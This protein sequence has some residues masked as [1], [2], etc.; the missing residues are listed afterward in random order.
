VAHLKISLLG[1][2]PA[3]EETDPEAYRLALQAKYFW[4]RRSPGD[5]EKA[6]EYYQQALD[7]D[8][9]YALAWAGLSVAYAVQA[10]DGRIS[11]ETG[12]LKAREAVEMALSLDPGSSDAHV[13]MAQ[14]YSRDDNQEA[15]RREYQLALD[16]DP[17]SPLALGAM[18]SSIWKD[19]YLEEGI[20][21]YKNAE[22]IDPLAPIWPGN[23]AHLF[24]LAGRLDEAEEAARKALELSPE[25]NSGQTLAAIL[26]FRGQFDESLELTESIPESPNKTFDLMVTYQAMGRQAESDAAMKRLISGPGGQDGHL[27]AEAYASRDEIDKAFDWL[28]KAHEERNLRFGVIK[29]DP[30]LKNLHGDPRWDAFIAKL[31]TLL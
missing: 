5:E 29:F 27:I 14:A 25:S 7:V 12:L 22:A 10:L 13:R 4:N 1:A 17:N 9:D 21:L 3:I 24:F 31:E 28:N 2:A 6:M 18:A 8:P 23:M 11:R 15:A 19:G 26:L 30:Y 20:K 16:L